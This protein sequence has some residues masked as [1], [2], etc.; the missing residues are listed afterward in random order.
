MI[1]CIA[2]ACFLPLIFTICGPR[3]DPNLH[4]DKRGE[5]I[6]LVQDSPGRD[7]THKTMEFATEAVFMSRASG[8]QVVDYGWSAEL[9]EGSKDEYNVRF[10]YK[11]GDQLNDALWSANVTTKE[12]KV[13]NPLAHKF[14]W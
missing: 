11:E 9:I 3:V 6:K 1:R 2:L 13:K 10:S 7:K 5:A 4:K 14:S 12:V 8:K